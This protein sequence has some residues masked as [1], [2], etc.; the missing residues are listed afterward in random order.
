[1]SGSSSLA[2]IQTTLLT[3]S[4]PT[5][6]CS[7]HACLKYQFPTT[8]AVCQKLNAALCYAAGSRRKRHL[9]AGPVLSTA[10]V[11]IIKKLS[12]IND[13]CRSANRCST[14]GKTE[15]CRG[16]HRSPPEVNQRPGMVI[17]IPLTFMALHFKK[18]KKRNVSRA[19]SSAFNRKRDNCC[20]P[21]IGNARSW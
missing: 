15:R 11:R 1:M 3:S 2:G 13:L 4:I 18:K 7:L 8:R 17:L 14:Y 9:S 5:L 21:L 12:F 16:L 19:R 20:L 10:S 6:L